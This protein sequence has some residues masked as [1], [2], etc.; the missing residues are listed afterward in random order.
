MVAFLAHDAAA[1]LV[2]HGYGKSSAI[3]GQS[4]ERLAQSN[5]PSH[6]NPPKMI[7]KNNNKSQNTHTHKQNTTKHSYEP[8]LPSAKR[9]LAVMEARHVVQRVK[10]Q[11]LDDTNERY[12][13]YYRFVDPWQVK[14]CMHYPHACMRACKEG[15]REGPTAIIQGERGQKLNYVYPS[16]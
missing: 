1:W 2:K 12:G 3:A 9:A 4:E 14:G 8:D 6:A 13:L 7:S 10:A 15:R 16:N 11:G 5:Q